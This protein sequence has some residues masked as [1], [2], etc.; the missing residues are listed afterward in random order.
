MWK[1]PLLSADGSS[2]FQLTACAS[3]DGKLLHLL[4][5]CNWSALASKQ[6]KP[7]KLLG[8]QGLKFVK[9]EFTS[10]KKYIFITF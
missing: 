9:L 3:L 5:N 10:L 4:I 1:M 7:S 2:Y 8:I 6:K